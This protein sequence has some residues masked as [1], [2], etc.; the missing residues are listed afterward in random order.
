MIDWLTI[1]GIRCS[2]DPK[3]LEHGARTETNENGEI[4]MNWKKPK[5]VKGSFDSQVSVRIDPRKLHSPQ[6]N[7][8][9]L[10]CLEISGNPSKLFQGHNLFGSNDVRGLS[11]AMAFYVLERLGIEPTDQEAQGIREGLF[12]L[13]RVDIT[14]SWALDSRAQV[15]AAIQTLERCSHLR[16]RGRGIMRGSTVY[17]GK[18]SRRWALKA[19]CKAQEIEVKGH[20]IHEGHPQCDLL[21]AHAE[22]LLRVELCLRGKELQGNRFTELDCICSWREST[23]E[24][25]FQRY[26]RN[27]E[28]ADSVVIAANTLEGLPSRLQAAYQLWM[29]GHD[30]RGMYKP[31]TFYRNRKQ[32]Q[33]HGIDIANK[34][35]PLAEN[36]DNIISLKELFQKPCA[37]VPSWAQDTKSYFDPALPQGFDFDK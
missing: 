8:L 29:D 3:A 37:P 16:H 2:F 24:E 25:Q 11:K 35:S 4:V 7:G 31:A 26:F 34:R 5:P 18:H 9:S 10:G 28:I 32:L 30:M 15:L 17:W 21:A 14:E 19:Y 22:N 1:H 6:A 13:S 20:G 33:E 27:L 36:Q 12:Y 23:A